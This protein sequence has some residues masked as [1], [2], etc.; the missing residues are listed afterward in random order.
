M[1]VI[2]IQKKKKQ[3]TTKNYEKRKLN[4]KNLIECL[5]NNIQKKEKEREIQNIYS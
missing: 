1:V 2:R 3:T 5:Q 4:Y